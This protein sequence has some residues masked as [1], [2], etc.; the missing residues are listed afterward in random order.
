MEFHWKIAKLVHVSREPLKVYLFSAKTIITYFEG[1][2]AQAA[3][4][5]RPT[6]SNLG[7]RSFTTT[8]FK[9]GVY[10]INFLFQN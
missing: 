2:E 7:G 9:S 1:F 4:P 8:V 3:Y 5:K 10:Q 6:S